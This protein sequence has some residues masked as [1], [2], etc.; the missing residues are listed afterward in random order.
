MNVSDNHTCA[1]APFCVPG[2]RHSICPP[3]LRQPQGEGAKGGNPLPSVVHL[4]A[5]KGIRGGGE[6]CFSSA[7][8]K[9]C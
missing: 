6:G 7:T 4:V 5:W 1:V 3:G 2:A 8:L 9:F